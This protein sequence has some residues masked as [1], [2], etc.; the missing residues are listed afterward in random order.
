MKGVIT[1]FGK[2]K[3][4]IIAKVCVL[5]SDRGVN[6]L[7]ISQTILQGYFN[8]MMIV[9]LEQLTVDFNALVDEL[10][11]VGKSLQVE[12]KLQHEAIFDCMHRL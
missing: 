5:L 12:I 6:I 7:D 2:D 9:D 10:Q 8:M 3:V 4:G 11:D 1:V